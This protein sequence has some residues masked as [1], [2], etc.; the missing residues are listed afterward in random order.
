MLF[1]EVGPL[2]DYRLQ[3]A[4]VLGSLPPASIDALRLARMS[5]TAGYLQQRMALEQIDQHFAAQNIPYLVIK[6]AHVRECVYPDP[7]LRPANDMDILVSPQD[8]QR[9]ARAT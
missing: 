1:Q 7:A 5:A 8:R 4:D 6:G 2:W 9:A 3:P